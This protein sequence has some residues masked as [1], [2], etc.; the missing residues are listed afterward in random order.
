[1][2]PDNV[3]PEY[4]NLAILHDW[5][6]E[7]AECFTRDCLFQ[8]DAFAEDNGFS[9]A[10]RKGLRQDADRTAWHEL[11]GHAGFDSHLSDR[12]GVVS[13]KVAR[14]EGTLSTGEV[15]YRISGE[16]EGMG[17]RTDHERFM[18]ALGP[19]LLGEVDPS[20]KMSEKDAFILAMKHCCELSETDLNIA[21]EA[22]VG[23]LPDTELE[24]L[25]VEQPAFTAVLNPLRSGR[26]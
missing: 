14:A 20:L 18:I 23:G 5:Q 26:K 12:G 1:M 11:R 19:A 10:A 2:S 22:V 8:A 6:G 7:E 15:N 25:L 9:T 4:R 13:F 17:E 24:Q 21:L 3:H 16:Y